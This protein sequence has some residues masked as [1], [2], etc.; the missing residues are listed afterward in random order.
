MAFDKE[1]KMAVEEGLKKDPEYLGGKKLVFFENEEIDFSKKR[2]DVEVYLED[3]ACV[4]SYHVQIFG[5]HLQYACEDIIALV[6][7]KNPNALVTW[8]P[9]IEEDECILMTITTD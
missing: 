9:A 4:G 3:G 5:L 2:T 7:E 6:K 1:I 8:D